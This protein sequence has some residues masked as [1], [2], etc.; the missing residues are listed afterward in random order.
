MD[1]ELRNVVGQIFEPEMG[2]DFDRHHVPR[3]GQGLAQTSGPEVLFFIILRDPSVIVVPVGHRRVHDDGGW[4]VAAIE[5]RGINQRLERGPGLALGL[6]HAVELAVMEVVPA[7][8][9]L[10]LTG[11]QVDGNE[12]ALGLR[13]A[14]LPALLALAQG[15]DAVA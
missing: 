10:D 3:E 14:V 12:G 9:R 7:D 2:R 4:G 5:R 11:G 8:H 13:G 6:G 15:V 1:T